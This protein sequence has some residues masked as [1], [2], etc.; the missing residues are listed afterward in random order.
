MNSF[1]AFPE[2]SE[3]TL[4]LPN[5]PQLFP[6]LSPF[7][8]ISCTGTRISSEIGTH[9]EAKSEPGQLLTLQT[10]AKLRAHP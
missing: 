3:D 9:I 4:K 5:S 10:S 2:R 8:T 6:A 7:S 1:K